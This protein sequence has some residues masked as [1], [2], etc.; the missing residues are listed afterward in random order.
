[1][2]QQPQGAPSCP[3]SFTQVAR[4][5]KDV[6]EPLSLQASPAQPSLWGR[7]STWTLHFWVSKEACAKG[8]YGQDAAPRA[9]SLRS[10]GQVDAGCRADGRWGERWG[11]GGCF[12]G[13]QAD[14][15]FRPRETTV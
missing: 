6:R 5:L 11:G 14:L 10:P 4:A 1:M 12:D 3:Q 13:L 15:N 9:R 7:E 8:A 2:G